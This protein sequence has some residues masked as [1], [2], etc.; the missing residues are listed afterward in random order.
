MIFIPPI[1]LLNEIRDDQ[2]TRTVESV[3]T[4]NPCERDRNRNNITNNSF[5]NLG[6]Q[7]C[8]NC[9][10]SGNSTSHYSFAQLILLIGRLS[11]FDWYSFHQSLSSTTTLL[12][13]KFYSSPFCAIILTCSSSTVFSV[14]FIYLLCV[15]LMFGISYWFSQHT[16][17]SL[18]SA[19]HEWHIQDFIISLI[20]YYLAHQQEHQ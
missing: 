12:F 16:F 3:R 14:L 8:K 4:M 11:H 2:E 15:R 20:N 9:F 19:P 5:I 18:Y 10:F 1:Q 7:C 6:M 17:L 13:R